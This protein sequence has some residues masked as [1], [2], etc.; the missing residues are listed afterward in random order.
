MDSTDI[1]VSGA[2]LWAAGVPP[3]PLIQLPRWLSCPVD[4]KSKK[5]SSTPPMLYKVAQENLKCM[6]QQQSHVNSQAP[7]IM[8]HEAFLILLSS[9]IPAYTHT[10]EHCC[11]CVQNPG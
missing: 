5:S 1:F 10:S 8:Q 11:T 6:R 4:E 7:D 2:L 9:I 3:K